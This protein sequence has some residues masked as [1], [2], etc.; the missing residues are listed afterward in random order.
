M[1]NSAG[2]IGNAAGWKAAIYIAIFAFS[3]LSYRMQSA[4]LK[5]RLGGDGLGESYNDGDSSSYKHSNDSAKKST[6]ATKGR[7]KIAIMSSFVPNAAGVDPPPRLDEEY[8]PHV[9][10]KACY[11]YIWGTTSSSTR[12]T[13]STTV[14]RSGTGSASGPGTGSRTWR[15]AYETMIGFCTPIP[16]F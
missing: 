6:A 16:T 2:T 3:A 1:G 5:L 8:L 7:P 11:S 14:I 9:I 13:A 12:P 15:R 4:N 10:N